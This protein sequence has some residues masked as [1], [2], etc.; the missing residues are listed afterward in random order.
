MIFNQQ[1]KIYEFSRTFLEPQWSD[2]LKQYVTTGFDKE[3][4]W[5]S[6]KVPKDIINV[7][8]NH[9]LRINDNYPPQGNEIALIAREL[10]NYAI[11]AVAT[12][13]ID[14][15]YRP[16]VAYRYF[17]LK[18]PSRNDTVD[19]VGTLLK[20]WLNQW[21]NQNTLY[22]KLKPSAEHKI[23]K[24]PYLTSFLLKN[25]L[26][27][28]FYDEPLFKD[29]KTRN[30]QSQ[31]SLVVP[32]QYNLEDEQFHILALKLSQEYK[33]SLNWAY[34]VNKLEHPEQFTLIYSQDSLIIN[35]LNESYQS[36]SDNDSLDNSLSDVNL[37]ETNLK[38]C[39]IEI[40]K[41]KNLDHNFLKLSNYLEKIDSHNW[42]WESIIDQTFIHSSND[43]KNAKYRGLLAILMP[44]PQVFEWLYWIK[45]QNNQNFFL[46]GIKIQDQFINFLINEGI[47]NNIK[48][49]NHIDSIIIELLLE[50]SV[51]IK[52]HSLLKEKEYLFIKSSTF[53]KKYI[54]EWG[55]ILFYKISFEPSFKSDK[56]SQKIS[57]DWK[58][59]QKNQELLLEKKDYYEW[60]G[61]LFAQV[62]VYSLSAFLYQL[63]WGEIPIDI[64]TKADIKFASFQQSSRTSGL[65]KLSISNFIDELRFLLANIYLVLIQRISALF[66]HFFRK[67]R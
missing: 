19:G 28:Q 16:L 43:I 7:V 66:P 64:Y 67:M 11:L 62:K 3:I 40:A 21:E 6:K 14:N 10:K 17:W 50:E 27:K 48:I 56:L 25:D 29:I 42:H 26:I 2:N 33:V 4:G 34:N 59:L 49:Q 23:E 15:R 31:N 61:R 20:W 55:E 8:H 36:F 9:L 32:I 35:N 24:K 30:E 46:A 65:L 12:Q 60:M 52:S 1:A 39:L 41:N 47:I 63:S 57:S 37:T 51:N 44:S 18:K 13:L 45:E 5:E 22:Y 58:E 53:W 54:R 38:R